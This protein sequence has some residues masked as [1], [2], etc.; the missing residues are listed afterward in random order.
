MKA[1]EWQYSHSLRVQVQVIEVFGGLGTE[2]VRVWVPSNGEVAVLP[3]SD[4]SLGSAIDGTSGHRLT[5][6][7]AAAKIVEALASGML[8]APT[9]SVVEPLPHQLRALRDALVRQPGAD[10]PCG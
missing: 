8:V 3:A 4:L 9:Q 2:G 10:A 5:R 7:A 6:A 1:G